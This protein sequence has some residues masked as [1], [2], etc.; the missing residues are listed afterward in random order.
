MSQNLVNV[1]PLQKYLNL[2]YFLCK[3]LLTN[4]YL[5]GELWVTDKAPEPGENGVHKLQHGREGDHYDH[6]FGHQFNYGQSTS[7]DST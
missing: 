5:K 1:A 2:Q 4:I 3:C 7:S 6:N